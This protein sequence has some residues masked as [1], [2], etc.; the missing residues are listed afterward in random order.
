MSSYYGPGD[1]R[2]V[3]GHQGG[4]QALVPYQA[5]T[6]G[7]TPMVYSNGGWVPAYS[8]GGEIPGYFLGGLW[9]GIK[10]VAP[11]ALGVWAK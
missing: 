11:I 6:A 8:D 5:N 10:K 1:P 4:G 7:H 9:R 2:M 3:L